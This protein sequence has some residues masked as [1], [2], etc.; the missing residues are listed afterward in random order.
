[1]DTLTTLILTVL[2]NAIVTG[3]I[4]YLIQKKIDNSFAK[5]MEEV[6]VNL[7]K[8]LIEHQIKI[9]RTYPKSLEVLEAF[10][11]KFQYFLMLSSWSSR[12]TEKLF[13]SKEVVAQEDLMDLDKK[14]IKAIGD[15]ETY[16]LHNRIYL[17]DDSVRELEEIMNRS[18]TLCFHLSFCR[19]LSQKP[20][21][22]FP[23]WLEF[24]VT[25]GE[26]LFEKINPAD[27]NAA[28]VFIQ[29]IRDETNKLSVRLEKHYKSVAD[30][31]GKK[32]ES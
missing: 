30:T 32:D 11:E 18:R 28:I 21:E 26:P 16:L 27:K 10:N 23:L 5:K 3:V 1:M 17:P 19:H 9:S 20:E 14:E 31:I 8:S 29:I 12:L 25:R 22:L 24:E 4:V 15:C 6:R 2:A 13:S 7:Q